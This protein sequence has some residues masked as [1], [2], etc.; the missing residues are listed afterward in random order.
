M[1]FSHRLELDRGCL[2]GSERCAVHESQLCARK[3]P[4][5]DTPFENEEVM[6]EGIMTKNLIKD[7]LAALV[8]ELNE[9]TKNRD[10][11]KA[12]EF[13]QSLPLIPDPKIGGKVVVVMKRRPK[14]K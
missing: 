12:R 8:A 6:W 14:G 5:T 3:G 4:M 2:R 13:T 11:E 1:A 7:R 9:A 10:H